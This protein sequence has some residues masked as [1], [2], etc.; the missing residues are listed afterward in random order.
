MDRRQVE[1]VVARM[2]AEQ[3]AHRRQVEERAPARG[4]PVVCGLPWLARHGVGWLAALFEA[5]PAEVLA[6]AALVGAVDDLEGQHARA[7][8]GLL[9]RAGSGWSPGNV[10]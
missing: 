5:D 4:Q 7:I 8:A 3:V 10:P 6:R 2:L 9:P 1:L